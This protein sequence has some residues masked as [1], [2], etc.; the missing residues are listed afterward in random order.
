M[1]S[2]L[3]KILDS[4][5]MKILLSLGILFSAIPTLISDLNNNDINGYEHYGLIL[6]GLIFLVQAIKDINDVWE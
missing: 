5:Y 6:I 1:R 4:K 2:L 3:K